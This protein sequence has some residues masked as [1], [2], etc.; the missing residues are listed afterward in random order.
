MLYLFGAFLV[1]TGIKMLVLR[2]HGF[3]PRNNPCSGY[4]RSWY[5]P[6]RPTTDQRLPW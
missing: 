6:W 4:F 1:L 3:D 2:N 5:P